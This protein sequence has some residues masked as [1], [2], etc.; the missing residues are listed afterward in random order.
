M[1]YKICIFSE[2]FPLRAWSR[3]E[4]LDQTEYARN[5]SVSLLEYYQDYFGIDFPLPKID[6]IAVPEFGF[7][8]MENWGLITFRF[9]Y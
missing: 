6:I 7:N 3:P 2:S 8:A 5:L 4:V 9:I 1:T